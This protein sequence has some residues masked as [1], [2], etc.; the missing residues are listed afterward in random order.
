MA[1][2]RFIDRCTNE[3]L[4]LTDEEIE[5]VNQRL[6][7]TLMSDKRTIVVMLVS[8]LICS[9]GILFLWIMLTVVGLSHTQTMWVTSGS[10]AILIPVS[11]AVVLPRLYKHTIRQTLAACGHPICVGC[12]Y[13]LEGMT[14]AICPECGRETARDP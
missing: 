11:S 9:A 1:S 8:I 5:E 6:E 7:R 10:I 12:G 3:R 4:T 14:E 2:R 13:L